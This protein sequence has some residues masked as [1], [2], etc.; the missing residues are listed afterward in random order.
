MPILKPDCILPDPCDREFTAAQHAAVTGRRSPGNRRAAVQGTPVPGS[1]TRTPTCMSS[2][3]AGR[4]PRRYS[5]HR[6]SVRRSDG[7]SPLKGMAR[8]STPATT[9]SAPTAV[10]MSPGSW[11]PSCPTGPGYRPHG[12]PHAAW[13]VVRPLQPPN[14]DD[15]AGPPAARLRAPDPADPDIATIPCVKRQN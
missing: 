4:T 12:T 7:A 1:S 14:L 15:R 8:S 13:A 6:P 10:S 3:P 5:T 9:L 2:G 11:P